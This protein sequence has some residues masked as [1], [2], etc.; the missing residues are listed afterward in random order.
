MK[1]I[2]SPCSGAV[3]RIGITVKRRIQMLP[4]DEIMYCEAARNYTIL[5]LK[6]GENSR[7]KT[8]I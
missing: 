1:I 2:Q 5:Y 4:V 8:N 3:P 7:D 6:T